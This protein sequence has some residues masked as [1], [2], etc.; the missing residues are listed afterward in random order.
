MERKKKKMDRNGERERRKR[1]RET[2]YES[3]K[4]EKMERNTEREKK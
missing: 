1:W 2:Q 4:E 3:E